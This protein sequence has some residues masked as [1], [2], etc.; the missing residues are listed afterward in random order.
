[1]ISTKRL[2]ARDCALVQN[3]L[4]ELALNP[5]ISADILSDRLVQPPPC[6]EVAPMRKRV[7]SRA[8]PRSTAS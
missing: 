2:N 1:M 3:R 5:Q 7:R 8:M 4:S 6:A